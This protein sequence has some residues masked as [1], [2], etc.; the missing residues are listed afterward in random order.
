MSIGYS[1]NLVF[2]AAGITVLNE[3]GATLSGV[4]VTGHWSGLTTDTDAGVTGD[5]GAL[6]VDSDA[7]PNPNGTFTFTVDTATMAGYELDVNASEI[8]SRSSIRL[9]AASA[10]GVMHGQHR[11]MGV[12]G[13]LRCQFDCLM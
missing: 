9:P 12:I 2:A 7:L 11:Y 1:R 3:S 5:N 4:A 8:A 10:P 13:G 6:F